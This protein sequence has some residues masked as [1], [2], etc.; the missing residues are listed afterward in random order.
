[1]QLQLMAGFRGDFNK[2]ALADDSSDEECEVGAIKKK[3][4]AKLAGA[5]PAVEPHKLA[6][7]KGA[8]TWQTHSVAK[9]EKKDEVYG[10]RAGTSVSTV[11][12][13][14]GLSSVVDKSAH[15]A[16]GTRMAG[17]AEYVG[18]AVP[19]KK[20][21]AKPTR[22]VKPALLGPGSVELDVEINRVRASPAAYAEE[23]SKKF[24][25]F[26][27]DSK[28]F[29][30]P[31]DAESVETTVEGLEGFDETVAWLRKQAPAPPLLRTDALDAASQSYPDNFSD[32][33]WAEGLVFDVTAHRARAADEAL[34]RILSCDGDKLRRGRKIL[35]K[36]LTRFGYCLLEERDA[37]SNSSFK[38]LFCQTFR[39]KPKQ[40]HLQYQGYPIKDDDF[41]ELLLALPEPLPND[42]TRKLKQNHKIAIDASNPDKIVVTD[43]TDNSQVEISSA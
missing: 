30:A 43:H 16:Y 6:T 39:P 14:G 17:R 3:Q 21:R 35:D 25:G 18:P 41:L 28:S 9:E 20:P 22:Y 36:K 13:G 8:T 2:L 32:F 12:Q 7:Q 29:H 1:V 11:K 42:L 31:R 27:D 5:T 15:T 33:G 19:E 4:A 40:T 38:A 34:L 24:R 37:P 23:L 10:F 26:F